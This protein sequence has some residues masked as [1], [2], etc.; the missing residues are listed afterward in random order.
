[1]KCEKAGLG[2]LPKKISLIDLEESSPPGYSLP[3]TKSGPPFCLV[4]RLI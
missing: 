1:M 2:A 4:L 3:V